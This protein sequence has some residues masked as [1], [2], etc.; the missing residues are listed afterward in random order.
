MSILRKPKNVLSLTKT[1][2]RW[3]VLI[4]QG[5]NRL[6]ERWEHNELIIIYAFGNAGI[7]F[8]AKAHKEISQ[9][10]YPK[11]NLIIKCRPTI[12]KGSVVIRGGFMTVDEPGFSII[13]V[14]DGKISNSKMTASDLKEWYH[15]EKDTI[16]F[17]RVTKPTILNLT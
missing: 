7:S 6:L 16:L 8:T 2:N 17:P 1:G 14:K 5:D 11:K 15:R 3:N 13:K 12:C 4:R 10:L 9:K